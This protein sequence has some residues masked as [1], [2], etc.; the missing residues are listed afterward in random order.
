MLHAMPVAKPVATPR[1]Q[2][3]QGVRRRLDALLQRLAAMDL[4]GGSHPRLGDVQASDCNA[5][6]FF[7]ASLRTL[8]GHPALPL[9]VIYSATQPGPAVAPES[10]LLAA[11]NC[12]IRRSVRVARQTLRLR[13]STD[14]FHLD[15]TL[16]RFRFVCLACALVA[17]DLRHLSIP[18]FTRS[19]DCLPTA[20]P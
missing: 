14:R 15:R 13:P 19:P 11:C 1:C 9:I 5:F 12:R 16:S 17:V 3:D 18:D 20:E 7:P 2:L 10:P 6:D 8:L 4:D